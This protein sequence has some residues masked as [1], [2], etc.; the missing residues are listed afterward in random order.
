MPQVG[1]SVPRLEARDKVTGRAEYVYNLRLPGMLHGKIVRSTVA[2][3]R[4]RA[5]DT[6]AAAQRAGRA[7]GRHRR[8]HPQAHPRSVLRPGVP[9][10]AD[11]RARQG[12]PRR[13][14]GGGGARRRSACRRG[15]REPDRAPSTT[16]C[17]R[18]TTR[19]RRSTARSIVHDV[20]QAR[21]HV[22]GPQASRRPAQHQRRARLSP[23]LRRR[24]HGAWPRPITCSS[25]RSAPSR[26][27]ICRSSRSSRSPSPATTGSPSTPPRRCRRSC[28]ARSRACSDWPENRVRVKVPHLGGGFGAK[29]YIK[30]EALVGGA[31]ADRAQAGEDRAHDGGAVRHASPSIRRRSASRAA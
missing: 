23:A 21:R 29:V 2:H 5:I 27:C 25:T 11:P 7:C 14:A 9:R 4:I 22:S 20:L 12:S 16:N 24:R 28:A 13:R 19:S 15:G 8:R 18:S 10:P 31:G 6:R 30:L 26:C 3:G 17:R 1:R